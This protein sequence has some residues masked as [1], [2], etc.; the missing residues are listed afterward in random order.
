MSKRLIKQYCVDERK[1]RGKSKDNLQARDIKLAHRFYYHAEIK[2]EVFHIA[3]PKLAEEF[4]ISERVVLERL[5]TQQSLLDQLF[6]D[7]PTQHQLKNKYPYFHW[8]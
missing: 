1:K 4:N 7:S 6:K 2:S 3:I 5:R 8:S